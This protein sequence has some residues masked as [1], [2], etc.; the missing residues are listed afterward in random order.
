MMYSDYIPYWKYC[1]VR[2]LSMD[3]TA[4]KVVMLN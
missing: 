3:P 4:Y 1:G 2:K